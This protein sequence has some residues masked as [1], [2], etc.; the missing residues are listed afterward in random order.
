MG[1]SQ[2]TLESSENERNQHK[3]SNVSR[4]IQPDI[5]LHELIPFLAMMIATRSL[6]LEMR[7]F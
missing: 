7:W 4:N 3:E 1:A 6:I 5:R 2:F